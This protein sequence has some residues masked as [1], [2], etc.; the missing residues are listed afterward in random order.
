MALM[1]LSR[2][3]SDPSLYSFPLSKDILSAHEEIEELLES[4]LMDC[5]SLGEKLAYLMVTMQNAEDLMSLKLDTNRN[6][7]LMANTT[8]TIATVAIGFSAYVTGVYGMN[9]DQTI[10]IQNVYGLFETVFAVTFALI[11][12]ITAL[13]WYYYKRT[14][15]LPST[16]KV[17]H[18][19]N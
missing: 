13:I 2:L 8:L 6:E 1:N 15:V 17:R 16:I 18:H 3:R 9:L 12:I 11:F 14:G 19:V 7:L 5:N 4:H 10:T